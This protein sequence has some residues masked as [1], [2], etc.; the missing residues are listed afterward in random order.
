MFQS[1]RPRGRTRLPEKVQKVQSEMFQSTRPRGRTRP[2]SNRCA[3]F[4]LRCFNPRV[5]AGGRDTPSSRMQSSCIVSIHASSREDATSFAIFIS[6]FFF[7]SIHA[8]S[9]EDATSI[10]QC[11]TK[12]FVFQS[13]RPRGRTRRQT[14]KTIGIRRMFQSTRPRGRTRRARLKSHCTDTCFNPRVLAG[15]RDFESCAYVARYIMFQ[16]T[17]PRGRTRRMH[18]VKNVLPDGFNPRVLAGGRDPNIKRLRVGRAFQSTRP[19]G[20]TRPD[21]GQLAK[22]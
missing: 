13:T 22:I 3:T 8:S 15:G 14:H 19:R 2:D 18:Y 1:T 17:R 21:L 16:S 20:R 4:T 9:R 11:S 7:V 12:D 10:T 5:L 6:P